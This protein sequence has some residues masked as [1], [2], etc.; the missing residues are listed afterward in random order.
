VVWYSVTA[1]LDGIDPG[2]DIPVERMKFIIYQRRMQLDALKT[3]ALLLALLNP[4]KAD[5]AAKAY[6]DM[7]LPV[8]KAQQA[9]AAQRNEDL[10]KEIEKMG[11]I[12]LSSVIVGNPQAD[13]PGPQELRI[14]IKPSYPVLKGEPPK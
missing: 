11:P 1:M 5:E 10:V 13:Q 7:A 4:G 2:S 12:P 9:L 6:F 14:P 3:Q 8:D